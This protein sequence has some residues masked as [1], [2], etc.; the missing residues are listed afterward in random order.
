MKDERDREIS[1]KEVLERTGISRATL[2]NYIK[3]GI[4]PRPSVRIP[5]AGATGTKR[6]GY[7]P[8]W[9]LDRIDEVRRLKND[10]LSIEGIVDILGSAEKNRGE[11]YAAEE[12]L[13][14]YSLSEKNVKTPS[15]RRNDVERHGKNTARID[16]DSIGAPSYFINYKYEIEWINEAA[17]RGIFSRRVSAI[18]DEEERNIFRLI[19]DWEFRSNLTNW[20]ELLDV[21]VA[22]L[23]EHHLIDDAEELYDGMSRDELE[24]LKTSC[25]KA[26]YSGGESTIRRVPVRLDGRTGTD[27]YSLYVSFFREGILFIYEHR[28]ELL[29]GIM[30]YLHNRGAVIQ[31]LLSKKMPTLIPFA[32]LVADL[33]ESCRICAELPPE[34]YFEMIHEMRDI[35]ENVFKKYYGIH[36]K[37][38]GDGMV[39]YFLKQRDSNYIV[40]ALSCALEVKER[41][42][43]FSRRW[44][45]RKRW[46]NELY[47]NIGI[48]EGEEY[49]GVLRASSSIEFTALGETINYAARISY[50]ARFGSILVTKN[51]VN[52]LKN[53][54]RRMFVMGLRKSHPEGEVFV[55]N[56]FSRVID[57]TGPDDPLKAKFMDV[58]TVPVIELAGQR[59]EGPA[60]LR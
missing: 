43:E 21:H 50:L 6:I 13:T 57:L 3:M 17:E 51:L 60:A 12:R 11:Q 29:D 55:E 15:V 35:L 41:M 23:K 18:R 10:G 46:L 40:N 8:R 33:Q 16:L 48:N 49:F 9:V 38:A 47:L 14:D 59:E 52:K 58:A 31:E 7:F 44:K 4:L 24:L 34:E 20:D 45:D 54:D 22:L 27:D 56:I 39:Y 26:G 36:G 25:R 19:L 2:N 53:E 5:E 32:V 30:E 28:E 37:H 1:S 42:R